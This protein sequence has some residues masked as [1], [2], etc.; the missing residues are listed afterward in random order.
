MCITSSG[1]RGLWKNNANWK[2]TAP[3]LC[4]PNLDCW[5]Q[6]GHTEVWL[7]HSYSLSICRAEDQWF[8]CSVH[9]DLILAKMPAYNWAQVNFA[10]KDGRTNSMDCKMLPSQVQAK[11]QCPI[12][13]QHLLQRTHQGKNVHLHA[14]MHIYILHHLAHHA[15]EQ[16]NIEISVLN[17]PATFVLGLEAIG[18]KF[19]IASPFLFLPLKCNG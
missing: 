4:M 18:K 7:V 14:F 12:I 6:P 5:Y 16:G 13:N 10:C 15:C 2:D 17:R 9:F 19:L 1:L 3:V 11:M 8:N